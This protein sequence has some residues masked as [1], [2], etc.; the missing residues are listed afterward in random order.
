MSYLKK[1][2]KFVENLK[3]NPNIELLQFETFTPATEEQLKQANK[4]L[5][6]NLG[7]DVTDFFKE[8]NGLK[9]IYVFKDNEYYNDLVKLEKEIKKDWFYLYKNDYP[10]FNGCILIP[11]VELMCSEKFDFSQYDIPEPFIVEE[12]EI[13]DAKDVKAFCKTLKIF[14]AHSRFSYFNMYTFNGQTKIILTGDY[15]ADLFIGIEES[16]ASSFEEFMNYQLNIKE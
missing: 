12:E 3:S 7:D 2:N 10:R 15:G 8:T 5:G 14:N 13:E 16:D 1:I 6:T 9:L 4:K 11:P